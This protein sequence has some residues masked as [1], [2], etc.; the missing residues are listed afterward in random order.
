NVG[1][2]AFDVAWL[3]RALAEVR[4]SAV[5][6]ELYLP[7]LVGIARADRRPV[8]VYDIEDDGTLMGVNDRMELA[9]TEMDMRWRINERLMQAGVTMTSPGS[10]YVDATVELAEDV[11]LEPNVVLRGM[12]R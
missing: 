2:Y 4:P 5:T 6:G 8:A 1:L 9:A 12:T 7:A 3:R 10:T 11:T